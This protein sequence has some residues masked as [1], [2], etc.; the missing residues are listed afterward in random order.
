MLHLQSP[1]HCSLRFSSSILFSGSLK[2]LKR[3]V[4]KPKPSLLDKYLFC[5]TQKYI[6]IM[7]LSNVDREI[8]QK[9]S[10]TS[11][12]DNLNISIWSTSKPCFPFKKTIYLKHK[13]VWRHRRSK[14]KT[15]TI[16]TILP[17]QVSTFL[18][19]LN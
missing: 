8:N 10:R 16:I 1:P 11:G 18:S 14:D 6:V 19:L 12:Y 2:S 9:W 15:L 17:S 3:E 4:V 7:K 5:N 13:S